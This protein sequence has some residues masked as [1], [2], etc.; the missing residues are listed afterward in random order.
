MLYDAP[1]TAI[2]FKQAIK[3]VCNSCNVAIG[4]PKNVLLSA[5]LFGHYVKKEGREL[6]RPYLV[7]MFCD[8]VQGRLRKRPQFAININ[9]GAWGS[10]AADAAP[11]AP[12][13]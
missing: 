3:S 9:V 7:L 6:P 10:D 5:I 4:K 1:A 12:L 8:L 2:V 13:R 11:P